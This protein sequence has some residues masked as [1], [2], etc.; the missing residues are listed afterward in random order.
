MR[1]VIPQ[2]MHLP[3]WGVGPMRPW[4][5]YRVSRKERKLDGEPFAYYLET[6]DCVVSDEG[7]LGAELFN[8]ELQKVNIADH[9]SIS[10]FINRFG[11]PPSPL[12]A[13]HQRLSLYRER[14][15]LKY[16]PHLKSPALNKVNSNHLYADLVA[17]FNATPSSLNVNPLTCNS[18][19]DVLHAAVLSEAARMEETRDLSVHGVVSELEVVQ[20]IRLLQSATCVCSA[21]QS[22]CEQGQDADIERAARY[23][24]NKR[25]LP[26][27]GYR[28][29]LEDPYLENYD[30]RIE[31]DAEFANSA[32]NWERAG[33]SPR[34]SYESM[35]IEAFS[36]S[37]RRAL[38]FLQYGYLVSKD[39]AVLDVGEE[40]D[41]PRFGFT[42]SEPDLAHELSPEQKAALDEA[43]R[44]GSLTE[45]I[46][47]QYLSLL[48][49]D[50]P[51]QRCENCGRL[52][53]RPKGANPGK[54]L[55]TT[56]FCS[57]S[58]NVSFNQK[59]TAE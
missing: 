38:T 57:R 54:K 52:F 17:S 24:S 25:F 16:T 36:K 43:N 12:Y 14:R 35:Q 56:R 44:Y 32:L 50:S 20:T 13:G 28:Y 33:N 58:C 48:Y 42:G 37:A 31:H 5:R 19:G 23:V 30:E 55:R 41:S 45:A 22:E 2:Y 39:P 49:A 9:T 15:V 3:K 59:K 21:F 46:V 51:W 29:F 10:A 11:I 34:N 47:Q 27:T 6:G 40:S 7:D 8:E 18:M 53:K 1:N 4:I 26:E